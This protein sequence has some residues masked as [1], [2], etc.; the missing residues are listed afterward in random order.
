M[1]NDSKRSGEELRSSTDHHGDTAE[2]LSTKCVIGANCG[3]LHDINDEVA[4]NLN[5][6]NVTKK[7]RIVKVL[8]CTLI[9]LVLQKELKMSCQYA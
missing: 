8:H 6:S 5:L 4:S 3:M 1:E 9:K 7:N 2:K